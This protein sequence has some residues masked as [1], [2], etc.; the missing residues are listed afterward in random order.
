MNVPVNGWDLLLSKAR[1]SW[2][3]KSTTTFNPPL[4]HDSADK[5][6]KVQA[7]PAVEQSSNAE[8]NVEGSEPVKNERSPR[9][10][11]EKAHKSTSAIEALRPDV[12]SFIAMR[13]LKEG[14]ANKLDEDLPGTDPSGGLFGRQNKDQP[15]KKWN[16]VASDDNARPEEFLGSGAPPRKSWKV[17]S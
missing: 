1:K 6:D 14:D 7:A 13:H 2:A 10:L 4:V 11:L 8:D 17:K 5:K 16:P 3:P 12:S 15:Q 9:T